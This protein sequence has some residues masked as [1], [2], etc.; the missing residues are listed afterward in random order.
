[1]RAII[2]MLTHILYLKRLK[3][4]QES[5]SKWLPK[6]FRSYKGIDSVSPE[7]TMQS[8]SFI[9]CDYRVPEQNNNLHDF[10]KK[11][12]V[13]GDPSLIPANGP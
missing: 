7:I 6:E 5:H 2:S 8:H 1:M 11:V 12:I 13:A 3:L 10:T 4:G 9:G